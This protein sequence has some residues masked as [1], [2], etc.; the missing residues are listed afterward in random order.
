M[1][2]I[3]IEDKY[4]DAVRFLLKETYTLGKKLCSEHWVCGGA[5][6]TGAAPSIADIGEWRGKAASLEARQVELGGQKTVCRF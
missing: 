5:A 3:S 2:E 4:V 6:D 1:G